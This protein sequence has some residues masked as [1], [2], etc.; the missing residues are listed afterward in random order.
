MRSASLWNAFLLFGGWVRACG[1][2][3]HDGKEWTEEELADLEAKWG[4]E[5]RPV[6]YDASAEVQ[7]LVSPRVILHTPCSNDMKRMILMYTLAVFLRDRDLCAFRSYQVP[8]AADP[9]V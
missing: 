8:Y 3:N 9:A 1:H 6:Y 5:V 7:I 2:D 4:Y